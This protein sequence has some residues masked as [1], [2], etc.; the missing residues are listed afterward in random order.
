MVTRRGR[1]APSTYT[2]SGTHAGSLTMTKPDQNVTGPSAVLPATR[3][4]EHAT[5]VTV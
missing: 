5:N 1:A 3:L 2:S 4:G